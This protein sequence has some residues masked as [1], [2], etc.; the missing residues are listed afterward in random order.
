MILVRLPID[1]IIARLCLYRFFSCRPHGRR[2]PNDADEGDEKF[3]EK[4][5]LAGDA[6]MQ[7]HG[8]LL[9]LLEEDNQGDDDKENTSAERH[10]ISHRDNEQHKGAGS[11]G[12]A[13]VT[14]TRYSGRPKV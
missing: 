1:P 7:P 4:K 3:E 2:R 13:T 10:S 14:P 5:G 6:V 9:L 8:A 11:V 12:G